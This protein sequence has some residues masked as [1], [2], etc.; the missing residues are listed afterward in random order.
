MTRKYVNL[1]K[2]EYRTNDLQSRTLHAG[3]DNRVGYKNIF[4][5]NGELWFL[6]LHKFVVRYTQIVL[7]FMHFFTR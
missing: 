7:Y 4:L 1:M 3:L 2:Y 6:R 5:C